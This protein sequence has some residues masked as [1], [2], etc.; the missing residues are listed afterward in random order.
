VTLDKL[1]KLSPL[2]LCLAIGLSCNLSDRGSDN[3]GDPR[4]SR[5]S[6]S[7]S[8]T[9]DVSEGSWKGTVFENSVYHTRAMGESEE[10]NGG[11]KNQSDERKC[12]GVS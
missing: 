7:G 2:L 9:G 6:Q 3:E 10:H 1:R 4:N 12:N 5:S 8:E 11:S